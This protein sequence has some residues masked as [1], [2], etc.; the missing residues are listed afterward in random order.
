MTT[1]DSWEDQQ[2]ELTNGVKNLS[3]EP[4]LKFNP[5]ASEFVPSWLS[6]T[7]A[8]AP[9]APTPVVVAKPA[10]SPVKS[11]PVVDSKPSSAASSAPSSPPKSVKKSEPVA[12]GMWIVHCSFVLFLC[13]V[14]RD[15]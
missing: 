4:D 6:P 11:E 7:S 12:E 1:P 2:Q 10:P 3:V 8:E 13:R 9:A 5:N 14:S 15:R